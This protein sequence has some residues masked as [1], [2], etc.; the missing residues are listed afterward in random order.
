[1]LIG[2][3]AAE[4]LD[5][6]DIHSLG[7]VRIRDGAPIEVFSLGDEAASVDEPAELALAAT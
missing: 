1:L 6:F 5:G 7:V 3:R 2:E 4:L